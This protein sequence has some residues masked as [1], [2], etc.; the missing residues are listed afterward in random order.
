MLTN[1]CLCLRNVN[2]KKIE[3]QTT[4]FYSLGLDFSF[5][6]HIDDLLAFFK[7]V[8]NRAVCLHKQNKHDDHLKKLAQN[9]ELEMGE[10]ITK[11]QNI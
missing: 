4:Y 3:K 11:F 7:M 9:C 8:P 10:D 1:R 6:T 5:N 2:N